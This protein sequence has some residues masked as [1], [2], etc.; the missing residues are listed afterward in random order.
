MD[1]DLK[2]T[3]KIINSTQPP[4]ALFC[5]QNSYVPDLFSGF[6]TRKSDLVLIANGRQMRDWDELSEIFA[7]MFSFPSYYGRNWDALEE[8]IGDLSWIAF[9][10]LLLVISNADHVFSRE[11]KEM[12]IFL[13]VLK[14][15]GERWSKSIQDGEIWDRDARPF[16]TI[17]VFSNEANVKLNIPQIFG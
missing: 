17:F 5:K 10:K 9:D 16:H 8:C 2:K 11:P 6:D 4:Y 3:Q 1:F 13:D 12:D 15:A 14:C 7:N